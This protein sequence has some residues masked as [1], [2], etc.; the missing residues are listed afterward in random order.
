M[1]IEQKFVAA[2]MQ[3]TILGVWMILGDNSSLWPVVGLLFIVSG[4]YLVG[5]VVAKPVWRSL[6]S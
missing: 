2:G 1:D 5:R 3:L 4:T 6:R